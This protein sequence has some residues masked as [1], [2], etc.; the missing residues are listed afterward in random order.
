MADY[1]EDIY[2]KGNERQVA[3]AT[4]FF[5]PSS[6]IGK[7]V[8]DCG[9]GDGKITRWII[10]EGKPSEIFGFDLSPSQIEI[11]QN[12]SK[13][14]TFFVASFETFLDVRPDLEGY[15]DNV[16]SSLALHLAPSLNFAIKNIGRSL[17]PGGTLTAIYPVNAFLS[18]TY[19]KLLS[20]ERFAKYLADKEFCDFCQNMYPIVN[21]EE[22]YSPSVALGAYHAL[23]KSRIYRY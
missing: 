18:P 12:Q 15:F 16:I 8:L 13:S 19:R 4:R 20:D 11:A 5:H 6:F 14:G 22:G 3:T 10:E 9:C 2:S 21:P 17:K 7:R 1:F 23:K